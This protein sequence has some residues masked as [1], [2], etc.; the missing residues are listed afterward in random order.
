VRKSEQEAEVI[1]CQ[2]DFPHIS[3]AL[4]PNFP[5]RAGAR[6]VSAAGVFEPEVTSLAV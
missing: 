3:P 5:R 6:V 4:S 2:A 1:D